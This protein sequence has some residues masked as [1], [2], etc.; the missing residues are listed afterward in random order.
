MAAGLQ[1]AKG[2]NHAALQQADHHLVGILADHG[3]YA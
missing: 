3:V 2:S 1:A